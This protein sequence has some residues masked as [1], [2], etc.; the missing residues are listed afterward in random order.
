MSQHKHTL[1]G[2]VGPSGSGKST[3]I[4]KLIE[5]FP[6]LQIIKSTSTR[7]RRGPEDDLFYFPQI[8]QDEFQHQVDANEFIN[9]EYFAGNWYGTDNQKTMALLNTNCGVMA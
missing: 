9:T 6:H 1:Y 8:S 4:L 5:I 2:F 7:V 3:L